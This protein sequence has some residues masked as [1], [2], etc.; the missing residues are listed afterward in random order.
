MQ[1][2]LSFWVQDYGFQ[3]PIQI[4]L[5]TWYKTISAFWEIVTFALDPTSGFPEITQNNVLSLSLFRHHYHRFCYHYFVLF[6]IFSSSGTYPSSQ[7]LK[8]TKVKIL[9]IKINNGKFWKVALFMSPATLGGSS[10]HLAFIKL[11][12]NRA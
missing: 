4:V 1:V 3:Q 9:N 6:C 7:L 11:C 8:I 2:M 12:N 5:T 10:F